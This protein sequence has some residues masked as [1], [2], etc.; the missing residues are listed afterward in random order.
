MKLAY[1]ITIALS[2]LLTAAEPFIEKQDL[3]TVGE[4]PAYQ[5]YH[6]P[7]I[8]VTAKGTVLTWCEA[9]KRAAGVSDWDDIRILLRRSTDDGKTWNDGLLLDERKGVSYPDGVQDRHGLIWITYDRDRGGAGQG[10]ERARADGT[11]GRRGHGRRDRGCAGLRGRG[12]RR[13]RG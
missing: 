4:D 3:F 11:A 12:P 6:I 1:V 10:A 13:S 9:R 5:L 8:V 7:G 2:G